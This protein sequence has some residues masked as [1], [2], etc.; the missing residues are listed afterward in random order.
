M[1]VRHV[2]LEAASSDTRM[3]WFRNVHAPAFRHTSLGC[4]NDLLGNTS[5]MHGVKGSPALAE[6]LAF[7]ARTLY[8]VI[9]EVA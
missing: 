1:P 2:R 6:G 8:T 9:I 7:A 3:Q 5:S 4:H